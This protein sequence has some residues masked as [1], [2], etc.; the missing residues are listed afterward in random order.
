MAVPVTDDTLL[1]VIA[2]ADP[3]EGW[4][5]YHQSVLDWR[6]RNEAWQ[7]EHAGRVWEETAAGT[8]SEALGLIAH[9]ARGAGELP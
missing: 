1:A 5:A 6:A 2:S 7:R 4:E 9:C 8:L 3:P